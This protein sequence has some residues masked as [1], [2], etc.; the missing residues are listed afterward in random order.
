MSFRIYNLKVGFVEFAV[1]VTVGVSVAVFQG[2]PFL[3]SKQG[4]I[5]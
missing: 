5:G 4:V 3:S 2:Q 1:G